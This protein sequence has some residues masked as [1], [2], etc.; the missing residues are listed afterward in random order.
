VH[1]ITNII[2]KA[3]EEK[4]VCSTVFLDVAQA[5]DK[6]WHEGL[7]YNA[8]ILKSYLTERFF[9][10]NQGDAYSELKEIKVGIPQGSV[11]SPVLYLLYTSDLPK[12]ENSII[13][14][15][16][17]DTAILAVGSGN[18]EPAGKLQTTINEIQKWTKKWHIQLNES[19][20]AHINFTHRRFEHISVTINSQKI[21][22]AKTAKYLGMNSDAK[23]L[24][25]AHVKNKR[26]ELGLRYEKMYW[27]IERDSSLSLHNKI[28]LYKQILKPIW[29]YG[30][31][32]WG[33]TK[34]SNIDII[35]FHN[36]VFR[37]IV[38]SPWYIR[39]NDLHRDLEVD[40]VSSE[41]Q[42]FAQK[43]EE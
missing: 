18:E 9:R 33:C 38:N 32:L 17:D 7:N 42:R 25:K 23:L 4:Q 20:S 30:I 10:I 27:L 8:E 3:L 28:L 34:Q 36:K 1:R 11:L 22:H 26:D 5:F 6:F 41:I 15:F 2:E 43:H 29:T 37:N 14:M 39:N 12:L 35:R 16:A 19:N 40:A 24:W 13:G 21:P 31:R